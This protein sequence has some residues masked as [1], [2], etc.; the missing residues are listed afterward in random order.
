[1]SEK[2]IAKL[3]PWTGHKAKAKT[4]GKFFSL[5]AHHYPHLDQSNNLKKIYK[6]LSALIQAPFDEPTLEEYRDLIDIQK[7][8]NKI[9]QI[10]DWI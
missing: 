1:M 7:K 6:K 4:D 3:N 5:I 8:V 10:L 9:D 2:N